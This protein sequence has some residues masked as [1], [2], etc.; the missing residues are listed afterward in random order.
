[1]M[2][3]PIRLNVK[4]QG[5][6]LVTINAKVQTAYMSLAYSI[7]V[8]KVARSHINHILNNLQQRRL[9]I[10]SSLLS[11]VMTVCD[12]ALTA[13]NYCCWGDFART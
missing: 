7:V 9:A 4:G 11:P 10:A 12:L 5:V 13:H 8:C 6:F 2:R 1:M 3:I